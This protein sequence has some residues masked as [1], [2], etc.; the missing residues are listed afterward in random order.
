MGSLDYESV[1]SYAVCVNVSDTTDKTREACTSIKVTNVNEEPTVQAIAYNVT[2]DSAKGTSLGLLKGG[3]PEGDDLVYTILGGNTNDTFRIDYSDNKAFLILKN[4]IDYEAENEYELTIEVRESSTTDL[5][6]SRSNVTIAVIDVN[7][8][9]VTNIIANPTGMANGSLADLA[10]GGGEVVLIRGRNFGMAKGSDR[11]GV[12]SDSTVSATYQSDDGIEYTAT[13]CNVTVAN[14]EIRCVS[15]AGVGYGH[16]WTITISTPGT[17][18]WTHTSGTHTTSYAVPTITTVVRASNMPTTGNATVTLTGTNFGTLYNGCES[19]CTDTEGLLGDV[20]MVYYARTPN[21]LASSASR[22]HCSAAMVTVANQQ[23][24]CTTQAGVGDTLYWSVTIGAKPHGDGWTLSSTDTNPLNNGSYAA[25]SIANVSTGGRMT[26]SGGEKVK[27]EGIDMGPL[28]TSVDVVTYGGDEGYKY[29]ATACVVTVA[30]THIEC[31]SAPGIGTDLGWRVQIGNNTSPL[32]TATSS[33]RG[34]TVASNTEGVKAV[35]G[36]GATNG[37]TSGGELLVIAGTEF[38]PTGE[39]DTPTVWYGDVEGDSGRMYRARD[40]MVSVAYTQITCLTA[41]GVGF[42]HSLRAIVGEQSSTWY[43]ALISYNQPTVYYYLTEWED[44]ADQDGGVTEGGEYVVIVG[45]DFGTEDENAITYVT[46]GPTGME[47]EA[48]AGT[49]SKDYSTYAPTPNPAYDV[50]FSMY[51]EGDGNNWWYEVYNPFDHDIELDDYG[52]LQCING[53]ENPDTYEF[54]NPFTA[55][56]V[57]PSRSTYLVCSY[58]VA[59][60]ETGN[61]ESD[62]ALR[63]LC[64]ETVQNDM[65]S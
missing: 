50:M 43:N 39:V 54:W 52:V 65:V 6:S 30:H 47:Y 15:T 46:Y 14:T 27:L 34:P 49:S 20:A 64:N 42:N 13:R 37:G 36:S 9:A 7:D 24:V 55:G 11:E 12:V 31:V 10:T 38:G 33:Y 18:T 62:L 4:N 23:I 25:P 61:D 22:Y 63:E 32:S 56:A 28:G 2:E 16:K 58:N 45:N 59:Q 1:A 48:C 44:I 21:A 35:T 26:T 8:I 51:G 53:C 57:L 41:E 3:D 19:G 60:H 29:T 17:S 5:F 40:C